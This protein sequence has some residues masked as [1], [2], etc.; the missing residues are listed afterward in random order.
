MK[1]LL[2]SVLMAAACAHAQ[3][4]CMLGDSDRQWLESALHHWRIVERDMLKLAPRP[5]PKV[6]AADAK[7]TVVAEPTATDN[8]VWRGTA[9]T[10]TIQLPDGKSVPVG[11]VSF[12]APDPAG[13]DRAAFFVM[14]VPSVWRAKGVKSDLGLETLMDGVLLHEMT[15]TR[16]FQAVAP[17][18]AK[19]TQ[20]YGV[21]DDTS[22]DSLQEK[23]S[24]N[25]DYVRDYEA[26]RDLL[27][28]A[29]DAPTDA[30]ARKLAAQALAR[31]KER[32][33]KWFTGADEKWAPIDDVFL[34]MEGLGQWV[35][36][37]WFTSP[38]GP[39]LDPATAQ[40]E[41]RRKRKWWT[42]DEGLALFLVIDRLLPG[43]Q[44]RAFAAEPMMAE[45]LLTTAVAGR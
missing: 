33:A 13:G 6:V 11:P 2:S 27:Y 28:A 18:F 12:A 31:M 1:Y 25:A 15:H 8:F 16:Q 21:P 9:H 29:A 22:D 35:I 36:H 17:I 38:L 5:F 34:T 14:T 7:C 10:G 39:K 20:K 40:R 42:Q 19:L 30:E 23:Y 32:R 3:P 44:S 43:W 45:A 37:A 26:E 41:V 24:K 4:A